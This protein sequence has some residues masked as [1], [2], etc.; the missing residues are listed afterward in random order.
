MESSS[1]PTSIL[2]VDD[3]PLLRDRLAQAFRDRGYEVFVASGFDEA[4]EIVREQ[5]PDLAVLDLKMPGRSGLELLKEIKRM[6]PS[7]RALILT[8]Y[9]SIATTIEA[10]KRG[11]A[12]YLPKPADAEDIIAAFAR[13]SEDEEPPAE[14]DTPSLARVEWEHIHRVLA[15]SNQNVSEAA[16]RLGI[17]RR[18]LQRKL[19]RLAPP[20]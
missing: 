5:S 10:M 8:G 16:R 6:D 1:T 15:D 18:S 2:L 11:A 17:P 19:R 4:V 3:E 14:L 20:R 13:A 12:Y 9:G 7:I